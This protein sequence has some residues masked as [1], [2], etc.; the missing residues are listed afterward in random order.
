MKKLP[1]FLLSF[2]IVLFD[3]ITKYWA[4][5]NLSVYEGWSVMPCLKWILAFNTGAAFSFLDGAGAWHKLL[6]MIFSMSMSVLLVYWILNKKAKSTLEYIALSCILGGALGNLIDRLHY[7]YV[8]DFILVYYKT[9]QFPVFNVADSVIT[10]GGF[11]L[12]LGW[13]LQERKTC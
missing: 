8:I 11:C 6:F 2:M 1:W 7:G 10:I 13:W 9:H 4:V 5:K 12:F 3:Q